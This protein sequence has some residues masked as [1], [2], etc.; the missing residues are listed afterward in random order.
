[1]KQSI[2]MIS[3]QL[4]LFTAYSQNKFRRDYKL[5]SFFDGK[6]DTWS[7]WGE[8]DNTF[9]MNINKNGDIAHYKAN[10]EMVIY[11]SISSNVKEEKTIDGL[12]NYQ[13]I[14]ALDE[15]GNVFSFQL[16]DDVAIGLKMIYKNFMIQYSK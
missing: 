9:V 11:K 14:K 2:I 13:I 1:M 7:N 5:V 4:L 15:D 6:T 3:L 16:F 8:G 12:K 10:G